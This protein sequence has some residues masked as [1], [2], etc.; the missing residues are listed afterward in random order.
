MKIKSMKP[1]YLV[2]LAA[3]F[4]MSTCTE[5]EPPEPEEDTGNITIDF[6]HHVNGVEIIFDSLMY[7]NEAGNEYMVNEIQYFISDL[8]LY[9]HD[10]VVITIDEWDDIYYVDTDIN[11]TM[12]WQVFD[13]LPIGNY[14][15]ISFTFGI[16]QIKNI[17]Y[18]YVNPPERDMFWPSFLG[19]GY[20]YLKLNGKWKENPSNQITP[21]DFHMGIGQVYASNVVV[22]DSIT[23]YVQNYFNVSLPSSSF[24]LSKDETKHID[25][26]MNI[27]EWFK[28]PNTMNFDTLG[29]YIMQTQEHMNQAKENGYNVF[30]IDTIY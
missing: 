19:G 6:I 28:T 2:I 7:I 3:L 24:S 15:S 10:G 14:D 23:A 4:L 17:S 16:N 29:G 25:L 26:V 18:M 8:K 13:D 30:T 9:H 27:E 21:I 22:V 5:P 11:S 20:H 12:E 1:W